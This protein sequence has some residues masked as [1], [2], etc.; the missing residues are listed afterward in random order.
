MNEARQDDIEPRLMDELTDEIHINTAEIPEAV[1]F[2]LSAA[3][4]DFIY[5]IL[6]QPGGREALNARTAAR[7]AA[8]AKRKE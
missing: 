8:A 3:T 1:R 6:R 7:H 4:M 2:C 5:A